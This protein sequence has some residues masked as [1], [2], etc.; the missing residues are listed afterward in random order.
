MTP[1]GIKSS[2]LLFVLASFVVFCCATCVRSFTHPPT[3]SSSSVRHGRDVSVVRPSSMTIIRPSRDDGGGYHPRCG[4]LKWRDHHRRRR[5]PPLAMAA[6]VVPGG[7]ST[8]SSY[9]NN[10]DDDDDDDDAEEE[11]KEDRPPY[12]DGEALQSLFSRHCD[13]DGLM[14]REDVRGVPEIAAMLERGDLLPSE[15][16][17]VWNVAP[18]FP[19]AEVGTTT[20]TA[21]V[22]DRIDVDGFIQIYRDIDDMFE[23]DDNDDDDE[24]RGG[25]A[26]VLPDDDDD[27]ANRNDDGEDDELRGI[28]DALLAEDGGINGKDDA[29]SP[30]RLRRWEEVSSLIEGG[31]LGEDEFEALVGGAGRLD[32]GGFVRY[33]RALDGLFEFKDDDENESDD[34][35]SYDGDD[36]D[37]EVAV[38]RGGDDDA[39]QA[40]MAPPPTIVMGEDL[41]PGVLFSRLANENYLV[42][43]AELDMLKE[44]ELTTSELDALFDAAVKAP[45]T[46]DMLDEDGFCAL[47]GR[48]DDLFEN[49]EVV[50]EGGVGGNSDE[51]ELKEELLE[52]LGDIAKVSAE[53]GRLLCGLDSTELEQERVLEVVNELERE[54]YNQVVSSRSGGGSGTRKNNRGIVAV[55]SGFAN[56][57]L[58]GLD[59]DVR[60]SSKRGNSRDYECDDGHDHD[61]ADLRECTLQQPSTAMPTPETPLFS[62]THQLVYEITHESTEEST[63]GESLVVSR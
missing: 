42:E 51:R 57:S 46:R 33:N 19:Q 16:D 9:S 21:V 31:T 34:G 38:D 49:D 58:S 44:G 15:L 56:P 25:S 30:T 53:E 20:T 41:P 61:N 17:D 39:A 6:S 48:I 13:P 11:G 3:S 14:T 27:E 26:V 5:V 10:D 60:P 22:E 1:A 36:D 18:K 55:P 43:R 12:S 45:G 29:I 59:D 35:E 32:Y 62:P 23:D 47:Y 28:F 2:T 52:L 7:G 24:G 8:K 50:E 37:G 4:V 40:K 63:H 54:P